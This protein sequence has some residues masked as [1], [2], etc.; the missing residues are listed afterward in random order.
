MEFTLN[1]RQVDVPPAWQ[2]DRL[3]FVL[4]EAFGLVG[5]KFGCGLGQC[6]ACSVL[7]DGQPQRSCVLPV[8]ACAGR[9]VTTVEGLAAPDGRW[10]PVQQAWL[11]EA[12]PQCG[13]CQAGQIIGA[14]ALL[15]RQPRPSAAQIDE[16]M[17]GHLCRRGTQQRI[18]RAIRRAAG[19][20]THAPE[21]LR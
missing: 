21:T 17:S 18:R 1:G 16:A 14:V 19:A 9:E 2:E 5:P 13:Y 8:A 4:R 7:L 15:R 3:L 20:A 12:V 11:D 6:G 10:H